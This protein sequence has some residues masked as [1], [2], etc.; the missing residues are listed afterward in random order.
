MHLKTEP[1][2]RED[3]NLNK[4]YYEISKEKQGTGINRRLILN[5]EKLSDL[6]VLQA[7]K[8]LIRKREIRA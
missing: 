7:Y 8:T 5:N 3:N 4:V 1:S 6:E 2:K